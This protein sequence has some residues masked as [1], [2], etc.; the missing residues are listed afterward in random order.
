M[1]PRKSHTLSWSRYRLELGTRT[2]IMGIV[3]VTPDSFSDGGRFFS[4]QEAVRQGLRLVQEGADILDVGGES[5]RPYSDP[6]SEEEEIRRI[7]PVIEALAEAVSVPISIDTTKAAVAKRAL[8]AGASIINDVS[9]LRMDP[10]MA[11]LAAASAVPVIVMHMLGTPKTMQVAPEYADLYGE[12]RTFLGDAVNRAERAGVPRQWIIVDPG[13]GFGKT[14][15]HN[16]QL[17][18][19]LEAFA[20]LG[21][22]LLVGPSRKAFIRHLLKPEGGS[23]LPADLPVVETGT[24]ATVAAAVLQGAHIVRVHDVASTRATVTIIDAV[25]M[26]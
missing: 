10:A 18:G 15:A 23:D 26:G 2:A 17:I 25:R 22:P 13:I 11:D 4:P 14:L 20:S 12:V 19:G 16:L 3:N 9:A 6:V 7:S 8:E 5:T 21:C 24:Q 1:T